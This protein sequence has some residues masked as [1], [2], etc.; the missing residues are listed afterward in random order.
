MLIRWALDK[1][2]VVIPKSSRPARILENLAALDFSLSAGQIERLDGL[3]EDLV[4]GWDPT[5]AP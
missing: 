5:H 1:G 2:F 4:T 3:N